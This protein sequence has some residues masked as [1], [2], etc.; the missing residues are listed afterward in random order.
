[1]RELI[2]KI[3]KKILPKSLLPYFVLSN[4]QDPLRKYFYY[5]ILHFIY[6][7]KYYRKVRSKAFQKGRVF[8]CMMFSNEI[9]MLELRLN[10]LNSVVDYFVI[11]EGT[12]TFRNNDRETTFEDFSERLPNK[13]LNKIRYIKV[14]DFPNSDDPW[15]IEYHQRRQIMRGLHDLMENDYVWISDVDEIPNKNKVWEFGSFDQHYSY[16]YFNALKNFKLQCTIGLIGEQLIN[17]PDPQFFR[18]NRFYYGFVD[19]GGWH[20]SF[21]LTSEKII[22]KIQSYAHK[23]YDL[24]VFTDKKM[25]THRI[26]KLDDIFD[27]QNEDL[28]VKPFGTWLPETVYNNYEKYSKWIL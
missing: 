18:D 10:E 25:M 4:K 1:M 8:D 22:E 9:E 11:V 14:E 27:R 24:P 15:V 7:I 17:Y 16:Y 2:K 13:I 12:K 21:A 3:I 5:P 20:F 19:Q 26:K 6:D 28:Y 23:E